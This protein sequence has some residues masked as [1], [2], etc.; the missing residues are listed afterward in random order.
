[1]N[2]L[3]C[4]WP[5]LMSPWAWIFSARAWILASASSTD[6]LPAA[7]SVIWIVIYSRNWM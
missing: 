3:T 1:M 7:V 6:W 2:W 5:G 4:G